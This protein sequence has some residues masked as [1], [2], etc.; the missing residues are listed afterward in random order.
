MANF[1]FFFFSFLFPKVVLKNTSGTLKKLTKLAEK[2]FFFF[3][4]VG[5]VLRG[6]RKKVNRTGEGS[7]GV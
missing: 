5:V 7:L 4:P 6:E 2:N 1:F 3:F